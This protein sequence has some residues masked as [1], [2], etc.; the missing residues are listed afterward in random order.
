MFAVLISQLLPVQRAI[1]FVCSNLKGNIVY[2]S[3]YIPWHR[4]CYRAVSC[5]KITCH[6]RVLF[7]STYL[8][9]LVFK[10]SAWS[11]NADFLKPAGKKRKLQRQSCNFSETL[12]KNYLSSEDVKAANLDF[13]W[14]PIAKKKK[15][16]TVRLISEILQFLRCE[17]FYNRHNGVL[18][19]LKTA[20][21]I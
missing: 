19:F 15:T 3:L 2:I 13:L 1:Y 14:K 7:R 9:T 20:L 18:L 10:L 6:L 21:M 12:A 5:E 4:I 16:D 17:I 8:P 11:R